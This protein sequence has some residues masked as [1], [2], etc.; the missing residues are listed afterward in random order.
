MEQK[1]CEAIIYDHDRDL[2]VTRVGW[3]VVPDNDQGD[4]R[5]WR[6]VN[7]SSLF[8]KSLNRIIV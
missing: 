7:I 2:C 6:A 8:Y 3:V 1:G 5:H 4:F